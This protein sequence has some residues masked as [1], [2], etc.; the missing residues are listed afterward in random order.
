MPSDP[1]GGWGGGRAKRRGG[2]GTVG[3][4]GVRCRGEW[5]STLTV[6][7]SVVTPYSITPVPNSSLFNCEYLVQLQG[8]IVDD[9]LS[10][11]NYVMLYVIVQTVQYVCYAK[12]RFDGSPDVLT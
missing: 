5:G 10:L 8:A 11:V 6:S 7:S 4:T 9:H 3:V 12:Q 2:L 1:D